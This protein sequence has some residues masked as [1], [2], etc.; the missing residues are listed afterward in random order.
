MDDNYEKIIKLSVAFR[1]ALEKA[2]NNGD[3]KC[4]QP[5]CNFPK[6]CCGETSE[7]LAQ[8]LLKNNIKT[9]YVSGTYYLDFYNTQS[10]AWLETGNFIID[11]TADQFTNNKIFEG[12]DKYGNPARNNLKKWYEIIEKYIEKI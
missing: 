7:L 11:I 1:N 3:F 2:K 9:N 8:F 6:G 12:F 5:F 10:H 4:I